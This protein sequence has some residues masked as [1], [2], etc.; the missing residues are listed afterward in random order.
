MA[1]LNYLCWRE[2][3]GGKKGNG[4]YCG[5]MEKKTEKDKKTTKDKKIRKDNKK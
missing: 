5:A 3:G 1:G 2:G 4:R